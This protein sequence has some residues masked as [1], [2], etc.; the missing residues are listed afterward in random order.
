M[1]EETAGSDAQSAPEQP[2][3]EQAPVDTS[4]GAYFD[5]SNSEG[6]AQTPEEKQ[7]SYAADRA[8]LKQEHA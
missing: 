5:S 6:V 8:R 1:T 3:S 7:A 2:E 4:D